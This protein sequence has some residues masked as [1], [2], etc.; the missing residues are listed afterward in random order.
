MRVTKSYGN[1]AENV[2]MKKSYENR[3]NEKI[4]IRSFSVDRNYSLI[5]GQ[6]DFFE[7][8]FIFNGFVDILVKNLLTNSKCSFAYYF[9]D[10]KFLA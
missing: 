1:R 4:Q 8:F 5:C 6:R 7:D 10:E 9:V 2:R 3:T